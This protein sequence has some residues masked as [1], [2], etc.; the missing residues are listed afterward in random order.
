LAKAKPQK[1]KAHRFVL[2]MGLF[3]K[4][5]CE[6]GSSFSSQK[7]MGRHA[8]TGTHTHVLAHHPHKK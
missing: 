4:L 3:P 6:L 1:Q 5:K 8:T 2:A 7:H